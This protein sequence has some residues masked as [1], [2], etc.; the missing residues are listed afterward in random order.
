MSGLVKPSE[1]L[2][3]RATMVK[4]SAGVPRDGHDR[5]MVVPFGGGTPRAHTRVT[6]F[7]D[8]LEDKSAIATWGKRMV[9]VG[10]ARQP[11]LLDHAG[12]LDPATPDGKRKLDGIAERAAKIGGAEDKADKGTQ[13]HTLS[14]YVDRNEP[15]PRCS[16]ADLADMAAYHL[17]TIDLDVLHIEQLVAIEQIDAAGTPDRICFFDGLD[18]DGNPA[19]NLITD[20]KTGNVEYGALKMAMQLATYSRGRFYD[21]TVFPAP[22]RAD[23]EKA[24]QKW[25]KTVFTADEAAKA[26]TDLPSVNQRWGL[27]IHLPA[28]TG[29]CAVWWIDLAL[30]WEAVGVASQVRELRS[31]KRLMQPFS[32]GYV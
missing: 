11:A 7:V 3:P 14:E 1:F 16:E 13:L 8:V 17:A 32:D 28:G 2:D 31:R 15:L 22:R 10:T 27:I 9:L 20:L 30:G 6:T 25:R 5:P 24:W 21:H 4:A 26:Y 18:P 23:D 12:G 19:G 29:T